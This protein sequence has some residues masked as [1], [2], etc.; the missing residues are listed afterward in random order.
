MDVCTVVCCW[1]PGA[2][3]QMLAVRDEFVGRD[4]DDPDAWWPDR[5][6]VIGGRDRVAGGTWCAC[7]VTG[8]AVAVVLNRPERR[9]AEPGAASR[10][11]LPLLA[12]DHG[13]AWAEHVEVPPMASF[14][15][16]LATPDALRWW[17]FD[18]TALVGSQLD[19]GTHLAKPRG[20]ADEQ[21]DRRPRRPAAVD[22]SCS[23]TASPAPTRQDCSC[24]SSTRTASTAPSSPS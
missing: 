19:P 24:A 9:A 1:A 16:M 6:H 7:D 11:V 10:G 2:A 4:F 5:P 22:S 3:V 18:G 8:G 17:T 13:P 14:N 20:L 21:L 12:L 23:P 15:L